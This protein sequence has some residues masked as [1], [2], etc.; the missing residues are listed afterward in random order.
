MNSNS[1]K[2]DTVASMDFSKTKEKPEETVLVP[3][4][5]MPD[6]Y[7]GPDPYVPTVPDLKI[8]DMDSVDGDEI[9]GFDPYDTAVFVKK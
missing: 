9:D 5:P 3:D 1:K 7:S 6:I 4:V 8:I 2:R